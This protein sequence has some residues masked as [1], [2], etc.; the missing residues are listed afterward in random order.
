[1]LLVCTLCQR[2][3]PRADFDVET[4]CLRCPAKLYACKACA[5]DPASGRSALE[6][7]HRC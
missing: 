6:A 2:E 5:P 3:R 7:R 4:I 1:M